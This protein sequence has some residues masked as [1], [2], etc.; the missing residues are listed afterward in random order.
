MAERGGVE[1][2]TRNNPPLTPPG[3][4]AEYRTSNIEHVVDHPNDV[5]DTYGRFIGDIQVRRGGSGQNINVWLAEQGWAFP[6][7]YSTMSAREINGAGACIVY[8]DAPQL[9]AVPPLRHSVLGDQAPRPVSNSNELEKRAANFLW[10][11]LST[12]VV[13]LPQ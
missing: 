6:A 5:F 13:V 7:L 4:G 9:D 1:A 10:L 12:T 11:T 3:R 2:G 8:Q